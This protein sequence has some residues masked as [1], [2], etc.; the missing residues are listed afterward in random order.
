MFI[1]VYGSPYCNILF[2]LKMSLIYDNRDNRNNGKNGRN[3]GC[4]KV[5]YNCDNGS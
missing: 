2:R 4:H 5:T 1:L 3:V